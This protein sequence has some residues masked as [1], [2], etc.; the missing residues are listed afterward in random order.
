MNISEVKKSL[1]RA[2]LYNG[3]EYTFTGC[4][5]RLNTEGKFYYQ[6]EIKD[7]KADSSLIVTALDKVEERSFGIESKNTC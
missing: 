1:G 3:K 2:V 5:L 7:S 4:I 6:A